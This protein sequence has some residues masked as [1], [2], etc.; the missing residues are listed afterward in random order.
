[1]Y[2]CRCEGCQMGQRNDVLLEEVAAFRR[3]PLIEDSLYTVHSIQQD[4]IIT[5]PRGH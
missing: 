3:C 5:N 2:M 1:M 4:L